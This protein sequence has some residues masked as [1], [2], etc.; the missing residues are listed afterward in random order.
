MDKKFKVCILGKAGW[1]ELRNLLV[2]NMIA[3]ETEEQ[4]SSVMEKLIAGMFR[5]TK[6][7]DK[8]RKKIGLKVLSEFEKRKIKSAEEE[9]DRQS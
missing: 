1:K 8:A 5:N 4:F 9:D 6:E 3:C 7:L 2:I